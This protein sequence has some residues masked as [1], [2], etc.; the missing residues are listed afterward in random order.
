MVT[1][2][3]QQRLG[4]TDNSWVWPI[5]TEYDQQRLGMTNGDVWQWSSIYCS[6]LTYAINLSSLIARHVT[7]SCDIFMWHNI[8]VFYV[9]IKRHKPQNTY[10]IAP[11]I[12]ITRSRSRKNGV[13]SGL[14]TLES[15][16]L[17]DS[18][19]GNSGDMLS[20]SAEPSNWS[21][22]SD[23]P[24]L[25]K[26][27]DS[28]NTNSWYSILLCTLHHGV[29][30]FC[31]DFNHIIICYLLQG[32]MYEKYTHLLVDNWF[33]GWGNTLWLSMSIEC[34]GQVR[35]LQS[36]NREDSLVAR[37]YLLHGKQECTDR[38]PKV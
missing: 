6:C 16:V 26:S 12:I 37:Q 28:I 34:E 29:F 35:K 1:K 4:M 21:L 25:Q 30:Y 27:M 5:V 13:S 38:H 11:A 22:Y 23:S 10:G 32:S 15:T 19:H 20:V 7:F 31:T 3:D 18:S 33:I 14:K 17:S 2:Y 36:E 8:V 9:S 24:Q